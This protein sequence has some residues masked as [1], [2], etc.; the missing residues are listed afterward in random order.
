MTVLVDGTSLRW[1]S[2]VPPT[3]Q[4]DSSLAETLLEIN[5]SPAESGSPAHHSSASRLLN[6]PHKGGHGVAWCWK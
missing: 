6:L 2:D 5:N 1:C 4:R 3:A